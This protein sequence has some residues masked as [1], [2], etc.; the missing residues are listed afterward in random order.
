M[1]S[2]KVIMCVH[3]FTCTT[4]NGQVR[5]SGE[6]IC[7]PQAPINLLTD[8]E[9]LYIIEIYL[10]VHSRLNTCLATD[11]VMKKDHFEFRNLGPD[12]CIK[13]LIL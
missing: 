1:I 2:M 4:W 12:I 13:N 9:K 7:L 11:I 8:P 3:I 10:K 5:E 6:V